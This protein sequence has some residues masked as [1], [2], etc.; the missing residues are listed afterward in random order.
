MSEGVETQ[1][2]CSCKKIM[3]QGQGDGISLDFIDKKYYLCNECATIMV[4]DAFKL[5]KKN[6]EMQ[7]N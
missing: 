5:I 7:K 6:K 4:N 2:C 3:I 1:A